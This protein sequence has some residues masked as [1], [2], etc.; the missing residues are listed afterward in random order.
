METEETR[1]ELRVEVRTSLIDT[2]ISVLFPLAD[3]YFNY[4][5]RT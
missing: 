3:R 1:G 5:E 2:C 4:P